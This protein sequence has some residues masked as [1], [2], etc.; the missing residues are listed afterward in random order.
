MGCFYYSFSYYRV[1]VCSIGLLQGNL[2]LSGPAAFNK[3]GF[4]DLLL[5][6]GAIQLFFTGAFLFLENKKKWKTIG[7]IIILQIVVSAWFALPFTFISKTP[8][9]T[10]D[11]AITAATSD[12]PLPGSIGLIRHSD[13]IMGPEAPALII[14]AFYENRPVVNHDL[15]SP[16][17]STAYLN[18]LKDTTLSLLTKGM[19]WAYISSDT[20][21]TEST[22]LK[23]KQQNTAEEQV[24]LISK[25]ATSIG[26]RVNPSQPG[27]LHLFHQYHH[28]WQAFVNGTPTGIRRV[29]HAFMA[30][31]LPA[32]KSEVELR[33]QPGRIQYILNYTSLLTLAVLLLIWFIISVGLKKQGKTV[34]DK[35]AVS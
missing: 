4:A 15:I 20:G 24:S 35:E 3:A 11:H 31:K 27:Y 32:G 2:P 18:F 5:I 10:I 22:S 26:F 1:C 16:T 19:P 21:L 7:A 28:R 12:P 30:V 25:S 8:V 13:R 33:Y 14:S 17:I 23:A 29:N 34:L 9:K 6:Q